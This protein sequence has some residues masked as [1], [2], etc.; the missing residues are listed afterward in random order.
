MIREELEKI[1]LKN[2]NDSITDS[3]LHQFSRE[4]IIGS[5]IPRLF[6]YTPANYESIRALETEEIFLSEIGTMNDIF[7]GL[8][9]KVDEKMIERLENIKDIAYIKSLSEENDN[10]LMWA[11]YADSYRGFCIEYD[12]R[13]LDSTLLYHLFPVV[14]M[15]KRNSP[16]NLKYIIGEHLDLK[17]MNEDHYY[18]NDTEDII[19][20]MSLFLVKPNCWSYEKE[21][22][23]VATYSQIF[24]TAEDVIE[25]EDCID[26]Y[27]IQKQVISVKDCIKSVYIGPRMKKYIREHIKE[28]CKEKLHGVPVFELKLSESDYK[29]EVISLN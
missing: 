6:R 15:Q 19:N 14:Y 7:E 2:E 4:Q 8:S 21:W 10:L 9:C 13:K 17:R 27:S 1:F 12:F 23:F 3:E 22:R 25:D 18:P 26:L 29:L 24:N 16:E 11:H 28:I 5:D 20:I